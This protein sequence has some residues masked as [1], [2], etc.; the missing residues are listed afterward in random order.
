MINELAKARLVLLILLLMDLS[1]VA[2]F[3]PVSSLQPLLVLA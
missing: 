3:G 2:E 1:E